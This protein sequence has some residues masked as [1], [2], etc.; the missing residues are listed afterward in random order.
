MS[1]KKERVY[2]DLSK[3]SEQNSFHI[4]LSQSNSAY[5]YDYTETGHSLKYTESDHNI[6]GKKENKDCL[7]GLGFVYP[8]QNNFISRSNK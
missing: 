6:D 3:E 4:D 2:L 8:H 7:C 5:F 1:F